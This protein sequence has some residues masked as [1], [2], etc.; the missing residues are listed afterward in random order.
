MA[1]HHV[2][3]HATTVEHELVLVLDREGKT[4]DRPLLWHWE[5]PP[6]H[7]QQTKRVLDIRR[8]SRSTTSGTRRHQ[9]NMNRSASDNTEALSCLEEGH[10]HVPE[11]ASCTGRC[12]SG[13][14]RGDFLGTGPSKST[15]LLWPSPPLDDKVS[16]LPQQPSPRPGLLLEGCAASSSQSTELLL[17]RA[18]LQQNQMPISLSS[19]RIEHRGSRKEGEASA[20]GEAKAKRS[21]RKHI[22]PT[23]FAVSRHI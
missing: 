6:A 21:D 23:L 18:F 15:A 8:E 17:A 9:M 2:Q 11:R 22:K 1:A 20:A 5:A 7:L 3:C 19:T 12:T 4:P 14:Q 10:K 16:I 13:L